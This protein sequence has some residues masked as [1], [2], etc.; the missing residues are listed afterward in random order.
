M[1]TNGLLMNEKLEYKYKEMVRLAEKSDDY[2]KSSFDDF[3]LL[4]ALGA[5]LAWKPLLD[6][7]V[8]DSG[9]VLLAGFL[10]ILFI[11]A[12]IGLYGLLKQSIAIFFL[13][14]SQVFEKEVR[15]ELNDG[16]SNTFH[17]TE[18]WKKRGGVTQRKIAVRFYSLFYFVLT[19]YPSV[20]LS[21]DNII[22]AFIYFFIA[23]IIVL[24]HHSTVK[25]IYDSK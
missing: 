24:I 18:N 13:E 9:Y 6:V 19:I 15:D 1:V 22:F 20:I 10:A 2:A 23:L 7:F 17:V 12:F 8:K 16:N 21:I 3:K 4:S 5:L 14:E 25:I 11:I